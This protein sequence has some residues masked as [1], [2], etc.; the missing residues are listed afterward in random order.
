MK[1]AEFSP[2]NV[3]CMS[4]HYHRSVDICPAVWNTIQNVNWYILWLFLRGVTPPSTLFLITCQ[5][6]LPKQNCIDLG[7]WNFLT[8]LSN[9]K[10]LHKIFFDNFPTPMTSSILKIVFFSKNATNHN[11][12]PILMIPDGNESWWPKFYE[13]YF[14]LF[15]RG[16]WR[17][18]MTSSIFQ[19]PLITYDVIDD[20][21]EV[22]PPKTNM[23]WNCLI[24]TQI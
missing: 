2:P 9:I 16:L 23:I 21:I 7:S 20:V 6:E 19:Y 12:W 1:S 22:G 13:K 8:C 4:A 24:K 17:H 15:L 11:F 5:V 18:Q 3:S 14:F 10:T